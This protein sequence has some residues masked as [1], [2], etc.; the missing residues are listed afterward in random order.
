MVWLALA[1]LIPQASAQCQATFDEV[2]DLG[3][4]ALEAFEGNDSG[5]FVK[6]T[7]DLDT[8]LPCLTGLLEPGEILLLHLVTLLDHWWHQNP[9]QASRALASIR[10]LDPG[11][12]L[13]TEVALVDP[14][15]IAWEES[16]PAPSRDEPTLV[17]PVVPWTF[18]RVEGASGLE[19]VPAGRPLLLQL[20]DTRDGHLRTWYLE[21]GGLPEG[22]ES[23]EGAE[24]RKWIQAGEDRN[25]PSSE[26][27]TPEA[28]TPEEPGSET[29]STPSGFSPWE[30]AGTARLTSGGICLLGGSTLA[31]VTWFVPMY[32]L[33]RPVSTTSYGWWQGGNAFGWGLAISGGVLAY[34]GWRR[35]RRTLGEGNPRHSLVLVPNGLVFQGVF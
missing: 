4:V 31:A 15:L 1:L 18:W 3:N 34:R 11:F 17:L 5:A 30:N 22:F 9:N 33:P 26:A 14:A 6:A 27:S 8:Q 32:V 12:Q 35:T 20:V 13:A 24:A 10:A 16:Q 7:Q 21:E 2:I 28:S 19:T 23:P 29:S 25:R